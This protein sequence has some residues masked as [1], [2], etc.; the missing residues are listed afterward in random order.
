MQLTNETAQTIQA[1][2]AA[3]DLKASMPV[4]QLRSSIVCKKQIGFCD[5]LGLVCL[6]LP[7]QLA[8]SLQSKQICE[9]AARPP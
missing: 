7:S 6:G 4:S 9:P 1:D 2:K 8:K 3:C 5:L